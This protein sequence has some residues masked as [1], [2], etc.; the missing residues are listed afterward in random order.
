[1][2]TINI[3]CKLP[4]STV[5]II[6]S[7]A[8]GPYPCRLPAAIAY[9]FDRPEQEEIVDLPQRTRHL[10]NFDPSLSR[11]LSICD[12]IIGH[13]ALITE[14]SMAI[15]RSAKAIDKNAEIGAHPLRV[16]NRQRRGQLPLQISFRNHMV[17]I[18]I[19]YAEK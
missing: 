7:K 13:A 4:Q 19:I 15:V 16:K 18:C 3:G 5:S 11:P 17:S 10:P 12:H 6:I 1:M 2:S 8:R 9:A 14:V